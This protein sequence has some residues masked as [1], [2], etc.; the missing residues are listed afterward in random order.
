MFLVAGATLLVAAAVFPRWIKW[1]RRWGATDD[2]VGR[3]MPG[4]DM[5]PE[6]HYVSNRAITVNAPP[7]CI[8]PWLVQMGYRRG[9]LYSYDFLDRLFGI[10]DESSAKEIHPEWQDLKVGDSIEVKKGPPFPVAILEPNATFV[11][12]NPEVGWTWQTCM[13]P[14]PDGTTRLVTRN[15]ADWKGAGARM[16]M[17]GMDIA[18]FIMVRRWLQVLKGR[19]EGMYSQQEPAGE[20]DPAP[21]LV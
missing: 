18:S 16:G 3:D 13:Y 14:Q 12:A 11:L 1:Q 19:A 9:G 2:E 4:D 6:P 21:A 5:I 17:P 20:E 8:Y 15:R 10:L 7:E